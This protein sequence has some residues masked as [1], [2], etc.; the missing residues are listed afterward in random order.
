M[1]TCT[2]CGKSKHESEFHKKPGA[3]DG[4]RKECRTCRKKIVLDSTRNLQDFYTTYRPNGGECD[5]GN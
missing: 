4:L 5:L 3:A 2:K 1:K